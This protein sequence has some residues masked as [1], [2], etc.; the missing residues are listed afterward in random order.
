MF[1]DEHN[2]HTWVYSGGR[3]RGSWPPPPD[4]RGKYPPSDFQK[5]T[6][7]KEKEG[8]KKQRLLGPFHNLVWGGGWQK[9]S[10]YDPVYI[11]MQK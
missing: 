7:K 5:G 11:K 9:N 3:Q 8:G 4:F 1:L 10:E 2:I 6:Q